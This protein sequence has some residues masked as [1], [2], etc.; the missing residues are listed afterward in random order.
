MPSNVPGPYR[1]EICYDVVELARG[2]WCGHHAGA[3]WIENHP[4]PPITGGGWQGKARRFLAVLDGDAPPP[5]W[6]ARVAGWGRDWIAPIVAGL[7]L[8][9]WDALNDVLRVAGALGI[10]IS[11]LYLILK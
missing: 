3:D 4:P 6:L 11:V 1:C 8:G 9:L 2:C 10:I 7:A 5:R